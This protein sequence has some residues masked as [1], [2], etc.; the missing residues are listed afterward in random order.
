M[1]LSAATSTAT[2]PILVRPTHASF[3]TEADVFVDMMQAGLGLTDA[4]R[5]RSEYPKRNKDVD[6]LGYH[7]AFCPST[8]SFIHDAVV[9]ELR[10]CLRGEGA[11]VLL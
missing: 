2:L 10:D 3:M 8:P 9:N 5:A 1:N 4:D 6:R 7:A 11:C